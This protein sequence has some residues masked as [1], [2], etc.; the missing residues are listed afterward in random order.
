MCQCHAGILAWTVVINQAAV[1]LPPGSCYPDYKTDE[2]RFREFYRKVATNE[3]VNDKTN[4]SRIFTALHPVQNRMA[5][6]LSRPVM[7]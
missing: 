1:L 3:T 2:S 7:G 4:D 6:L 5:R